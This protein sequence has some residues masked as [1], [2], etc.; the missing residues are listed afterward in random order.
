MCGVPKDA[1]FHGGSNDTIAGRVWLRRPEISPI[2]PDLKKKQTS[3]VNTVYYRWKF[4][5]GVVDTSEQFIGGVVD[6][7][8]QFIGGVE[9]N[10]KWSER[11]T[12]GSEENWFMKKL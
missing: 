6:T 2:C 3:V 10:S 4:I 8:E 9:K 12:Q 5:G 7:G 11:D 1:T